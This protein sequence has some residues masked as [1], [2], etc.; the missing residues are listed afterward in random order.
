MKII[1]IVDGFVTNSSS[2]SATIIIALRKGKDLKKIMKEIGI[3]AHLPLDF[4]GFTDDAVEEYIEENNLEVDHLTD[5]YDVLVTNV[6][7]ECWGDTIYQ[8]PKEEF[9]A[10]MEMLSRMERKGGENLKLLHFRES[11]FQ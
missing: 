8:I 6:G 11:Q 7:I 9:D 4:D 10:M 2:D 3:P 1:K 5:E